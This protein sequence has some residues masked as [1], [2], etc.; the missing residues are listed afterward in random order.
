MFRK[1][2]ERKVWYE[3]IVESYM[4]IASP[5]DRAGSSRDENDR[6]RI[7]LAVSD[8]HSSKERGCMM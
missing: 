1:T 6:K 5:T 2:D 7:R 4:E 3:W 8:L